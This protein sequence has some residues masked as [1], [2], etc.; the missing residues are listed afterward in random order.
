[1]LN[2]DALP[3]VDEYL[4]NQLR[5]HIDFLPKTQ[6]LKQIKSAAAST[7]ARK[8]L[9]HSPYNLCLFFPHFKA[10]DQP[11]EAEAEIR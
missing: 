1:M 3:K 8:G 6:S 10:G 4:H 5:A 9:K 11:S 2:K 7:T